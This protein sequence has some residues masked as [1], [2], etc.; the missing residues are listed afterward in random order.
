[1]ASDAEG[2]SYYPFEDF[3]LG[4]F[5]GG[6]VGLEE[7]TDAQRKAGWTDGDVMVG[8]TPAIVLYP[9]HG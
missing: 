9:E 5:E 3:D 8:G 6:E 7:L 4:A 1:M 2:N